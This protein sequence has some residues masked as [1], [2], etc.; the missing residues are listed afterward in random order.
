[1]IK[2]APKTVKTK[3]IF[4]IIPGKNSESIKLKL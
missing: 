4:L 3:G 2:K 1:M